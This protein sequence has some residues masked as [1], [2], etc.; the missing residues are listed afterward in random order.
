ML[1]EGLEPLEKLNISGDVNC[2]RAK[3]LVTS[4]DHAGQQGLVSKG[5]RFHSNYA[6]P[7]N[8]TIHT[9]DVYVCFMIV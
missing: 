8:V 3:T 4:I 6:T 1:K 7:K 9:R 5:F 2:Q